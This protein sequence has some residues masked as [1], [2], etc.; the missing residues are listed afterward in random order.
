[1]K[2]SGNIHNKYIQN[3]KQLLN[4]WATSPKLYS[5]DITRNTVMGASKQNH[6]RCVQSAVRK[7][8]Q[9]ACYGTKQ[10]TFRRKKLIDKS[11]RRRGGV[12]WLQNRK[13]NRWQRIQYE[14][15]REQFRK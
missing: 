6:N 11:G 8:A 13:R 12:M 15:K 10:S 5:G 3:Q 1:M 14:Q 2:T 7:N 9:K 4:K